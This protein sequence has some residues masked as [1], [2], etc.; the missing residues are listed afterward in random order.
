VIQKWVDVYE[1]ALE[2]IKTRKRLPRKEKLRLM[3]APAVDEI[4]R[5]MPLPLIPDENHPITGY[6]LD[7]LTGDEAVKLIAGAE[8]DSYIVCRVGPDGKP[9]LYEVLKRTERPLHRYLKG[10]LDD[11]SSLFSLEPK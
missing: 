3:P 9:P 1:E 5:K 11:G 7:G 8:D 10:V 2:R 6:I 4:L